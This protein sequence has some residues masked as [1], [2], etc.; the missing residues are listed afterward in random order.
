MH[1]SLAALADA[2]EAELVGNGDL[3]I[4]GLAEPASAGPR[5]LALATRDSY[6]E[7]LSKGAARAA[8][9]WPGADAAAYGLE[10]ALIPRRPRYA[11]SSLTRLADPGQGFAPGIS[12]HA[13][14]DP[15]AE[16]ASTSASAPSA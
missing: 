14:I 4:E 6:A 12:A 2:L 15:A 16:L 8:L 1:I 7:G 5:D 9:L 3:I 13:L 10:A 11:M